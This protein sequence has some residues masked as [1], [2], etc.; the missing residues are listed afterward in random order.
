MTAR[1]FVAGGDRWRVEEGASVGIA[2]GESGSYVS[3]TPDSYTIVFFHAIT[4]ERRQTNW[5]NPLSQCT[6][7]DLQ[8]MLEASRLT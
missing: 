8:I 1:I 7:E 4:R 6:V 2:A 5:H 3:E